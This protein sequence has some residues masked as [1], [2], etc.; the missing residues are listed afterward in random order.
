MHN[1][2]IFSFNLFC[3]VEQPSIPSKSK[4]FIPAN[5]CEMRCICCRCFFFLLRDVGNI[6]CFPLHTWVK[7]TTRFGM[8]FCA[9]VDGMNVWHFSPSSFPPLS[10]LSKCSLPL[11]LSRWLFAIHGFVHLIF[12]ILHFIWLLVFSDISIAYTQNTTYMHMKRNNLWLVACSRQVMPHCRFFV[13][14]V[15]NSSVSVSRPSIPHVYLLCQMD[16]E[17]FVVY[18]PQIFLS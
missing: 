16:M 15:C 7:W 2:R 11:S 1:L 18:R 5:R 4:S 9:V 6:I 10:F 17:R 12:L 14:F 8:H 3:S 13:L